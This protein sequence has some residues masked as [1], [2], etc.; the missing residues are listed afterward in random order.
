MSGHAGPAVF[1]RPG[2]HSTDLGQRMI[3]PW[4]P[5]RPPASASEA[6]CTARAEPIYAIP[7][8]RQADAP[9]VYLRGILSGAIG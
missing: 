3:P 1:S 4:T 9:C 2:R 7:R 5:R 8:C 6:H